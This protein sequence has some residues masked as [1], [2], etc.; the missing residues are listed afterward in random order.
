[1]N[2]HLKGCDSFARGS[3]VFCLVSRGLFLLLQSSC[4]AV[5]VDLGNEDAG[6]NQRHGQL[7][8]GDFRLLTGAVQRS[9][10]LPSE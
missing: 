10:H 3:S 9:I 8:A 7:P 2:P 6:T 4:V 1:M 5:V